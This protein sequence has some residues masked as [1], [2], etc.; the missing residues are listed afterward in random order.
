MSTG[1]GDRDDRGRPWKHCGVETALSL[2]FVAAVVVTVTATAER[3]RFS[4][5]CF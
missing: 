1:H 3:I 4:A 2:L 5:P